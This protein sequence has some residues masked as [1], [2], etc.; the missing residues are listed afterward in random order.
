MVIFIIKLSFLSLF[1]IC[2]VVLLGSQEEFMGRRSSDL[3]MLSGVGK[4][5]N[6][7]QVTQVEAAGG[8]GTCRVVNGNWV[9][10]GD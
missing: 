7:H 6:S 8:K 1:Q 5:Q 3:L 2:N 10:I 4:E 9:G